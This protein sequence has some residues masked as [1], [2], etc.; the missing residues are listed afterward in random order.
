MPLKLSD[1]TISTFDSAFE[2]FKAEAPN[3]KANFILFLA[4]KDP[5]TSL[6]WCP[7][8][9]FFLSFTSKTKNLFLCILFKKISATH[10]IIL[11]KLFDSVANSLS[12]FFGIFF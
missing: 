6:S 11:V 8:L 12:L 4:D 9:Y 7:G 5:S 2:K 1:A 10:Y 3:N